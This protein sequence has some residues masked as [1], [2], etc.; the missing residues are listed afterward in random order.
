MKINVSE[1]LKAIIPAA[2][3]V[4]GIT[5]EGAVSD[6]LEDLAIKAVNNVEELRELKGTAKRDEAVKQFLE[7]ALAVLGMA[8]PIGAANLF[9]EGAVLL[10]KMVK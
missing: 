1:L 10:L 4:Y 9:I 2:G 3:T 8:I 7:T 5:I 6:Q